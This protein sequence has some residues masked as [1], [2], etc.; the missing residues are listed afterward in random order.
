MLPQGS[1]LPSVHDYSFWWFFFYTILPPSLSPSSFC[2]LS[3]ALSDVIYASVAL[4]HMHASTYTSMVTKRTRA[5][6][7]KHIRVYSHLRKYFEIIYIC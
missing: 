5:H 4:T 2:C 3:A 6:T 7:H 1:A